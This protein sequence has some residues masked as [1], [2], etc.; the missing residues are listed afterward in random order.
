MS[1]ILES[2]LH[3]SVVQRRLTP[4]IPVLVPLLEKSVTS[5]FE[6]YFPQADDWVEM[7][8]YEVF[9]KISA[10]ANAPALVGPSFSDDPRWL[11]VAFHYSEYCK[12]DL[13]STFKT[14]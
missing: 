14:R 10:R 3:H 8:P 1:L 4:R 6:K 13:L 12:R 5:A 11:D 2:R 9:G 7:I